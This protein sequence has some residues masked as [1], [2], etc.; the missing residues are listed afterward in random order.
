MIRRL[1]DVVSIAAVLVLASA[2]A[3]AAPVDV[4]VLLAE[5]Q[6][7][8]GEITLTGELVG[9]YGRRG[10]GWVWAQLNDDP[11]AEHPLLERVAFA[12]GNVGVGIR[13]PY[14]LAD[15]LGPPGGY[16]RR[17]PLV[18]ATGTWIYHDA[19]RGGESYLEVASI[20]L[21]EPGRDLAEGPSWFRLAGGGVLLAAAAT[22]WI[23]RRR[24]ESWAGSR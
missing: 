20:V 2:S 15:R 6:A 16:R 18:E 14:E 3:L 21:I 13:M 9:D 12:G 23:T 11:Y 4:E 19:S 8:Q 7:F 5:P 24:P 1:V 22:L 17:G 10:D